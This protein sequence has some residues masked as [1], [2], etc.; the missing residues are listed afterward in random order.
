MKLRRIPIKLGKETREEQREAGRH[1]PSLVV[2]FRDRKGTH[3]V[4]INAG[5]YDDVE[6]FRSGDETFILTTNS[7]LEYVG[8][9]VFRGD[10]S[11]GDVF[12]QYDHEIKDVLGPRGLDQADY[13][14]VK[15]LSD[16]F[17]Y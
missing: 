17:T 5:Y 1:N 7:S 9:E 12:F 11:L 4:P 3:R 6:G 10:E 2:Y 14:I 15:I 16:C 8:L 13:N